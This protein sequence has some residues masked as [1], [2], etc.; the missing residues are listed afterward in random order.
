MNLSQATELYT[1]MT[2]CRHVKV[3]NVYISARFSNKKLPGCFMCEC[4][5][6]GLYTKKEGMELDDDIG[7]ADHFGCTQNEAHA[8]LFVKPKGELSIRADMTTGEGYYQAGKELLEKYGYGHL[9]EEAE[10]MKLRHYEGIEAAGYLSRDRMK[11]THKASPMSFEQ[12]IDELKVT[13]KED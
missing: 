4:V 7:F 3:M 13:I 9:F 2:T 1:G 11:I 6:H 5:R 12:Y 10:I 8:L